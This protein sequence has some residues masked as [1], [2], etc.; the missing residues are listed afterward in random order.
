MSSVSVAS[1]GPY[2]F[3][4]KIEGCAANAVPDPVHA[5]FGHAYG[6]VV[7]RL[8]RRKVPIV[9]VLLKVDAV[10]ETLLAEPAIVSLPVFVARPARALVLPEVFS[11]VPPARVSVVALVVIVCA[12]PVMFRFASST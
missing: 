8:M 12:V 10:V 6:F 5:G 4:A 11:I 1:L 9:P 3:P 7:T 2:L